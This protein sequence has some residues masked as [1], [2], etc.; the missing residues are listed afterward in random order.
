MRELLLE[1]GFSDV[2]FVQTLA[3]RSVIAAVR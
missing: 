1:V 3:D 2:R